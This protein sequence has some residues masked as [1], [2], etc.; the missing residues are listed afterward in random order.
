MGGVRHEVPGLVVEEGRSE[1]D[2]VEGEGRTEILGRE[3]AGQR[4]L[5]LWEK[6]GQ[7]VLWLW[8]RLDQRV[9]WWRE[10]VDQR[11]EMEPPYRGTSLVRNTS[12]V[13]PYSSPMPRDLR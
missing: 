9:L 3:R 13:G 2:L 5:W 12:P 1:C 6:A 11:R 10:R 8:E 4:L 7:R